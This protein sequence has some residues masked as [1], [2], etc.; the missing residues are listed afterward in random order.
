MEALCAVK[1]IMI[2]WL[3][4]VFFAAVQASY[5][6]NQDVLSGNGVNNSLLNTAYNNFFL[7]RIST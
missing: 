7:R 4:T 3:T 1:S 6:S 5:G 2:W